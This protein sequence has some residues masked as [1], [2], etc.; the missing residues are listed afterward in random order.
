M[1]K[2][3]L[4]LAL[5]ATFGCQETAEY[6]HGSMDHICALNAAGKLPEHLIPVYGDESIILANEADF[7]V[8]AAVALTKLRGPESDSLTA[9]E[10]RVWEDVLGYLPKVLEFRS[11][12][13]N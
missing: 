12:E 3:T 9:E 5:I 13:N 8:F 6:K 4:A 2:L 10:R 7:I 1:K 11:A